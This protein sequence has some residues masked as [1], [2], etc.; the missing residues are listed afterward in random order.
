MSLKI[1]IELMRELA[2]DRNGRCL[3][4]EYID[5]NTYL[6]WL[7]EKGHNFELTYTALKAGA[8]CKYCTMI[9]RRQVAI[10]LMQ[11]WATKRN[12]KCL[13]NTY[14]PK[15]KKWKWQCKKGH[16]FLMTRAIVNNG[17]WCPTCRIEEENG[18]N[19]FRMNELAAKFGGKCLSTK[20]IGTQINMEWECERGHR[21][22][23]S[24]ENVKRGAWCQ[25]CKNEDIWVEWY[26]EVLNYVGKKGGKLLTDKLTDSTTK[27]KIEC[28][29]GHTWK[30]SPRSLIYR[31]TWCP[32]CYGKVP[33]SLEEMK[34]TA[35]SHGGKCLS[36]V[37]VNSKTHLQW[38]CAKKHIWEAPY[39]N[40]QSGNWC[41]TC[42][43]EIV[44]RKMKAYK[45]AQK[46]R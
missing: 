34:A 9:D 3:S 24:R 4:K 32:Y 31:N 21:F 10:E 5:R 13:T 27:I 12:G 30:T 40:I 45:A 26:K 2:R 46:K 36:K 7:C 17:Q 1:N 15:G 14:V 43:Y 22:K 20:Y 8:W 23:M 19:I 42:G 18:R 44:S 39:H 6:K 37:Y 28:Q 11:E 35:R 16:I 33:L 29:K 41:P 38:Q 25:K